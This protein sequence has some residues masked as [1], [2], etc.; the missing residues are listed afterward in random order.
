MLKTI[1]MT[2]LCLAVVFAAGGPAHA[3]NYNLEKMKTIPRYKGLTQEEF[4]K[5]TKVIEETPPGDRHL[6]YSIRFPA[7]WKKADDSS[8]IYESGTKE[9]HALSRRILGKVSKFYGPAQIDATSY[10][11]VRALELD[12]QISARNWF[13][14]FIISNAY[15]LEGMEVISDRRVEALY[16]LNERGTSYVVRAI[17]EINGPRMVLASYY[18]PDA[19]W[20]EEKAM[21]EK[22]VGSFTFLTPEDTKIEA[23]RTYNYL[24]VLHFD[25]PAN[26]RLMAPEAYSLE[27][28]DAKLVNSRDDLTVSGEIE[29]HVVSTEMDTTL[30]Q[31][32]Q[33]L[34]E[35][36]KQTGLEIGDLIEVPDDHEFADHVLFSRVEVYRAKARKPGRRIIDHEFWLGIIVEDRYY[37]IVTMLTP[38]RNAEFYTWARNTEA[39]E[40]VAESMRP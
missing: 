10:F 11:E 33:A 5:Q 4:E 40:I 35:N 38:S 36:L 19:H 31:E 39:F 16:V 1:L 32:V 30:S 12:Y 21:Q 8:S 37:Y 29:I 15:S 22:V 7:G 14:N 23:T 26:W 24:D 6:A 28:M 17:A 13:L 18:L 9:K 34:R 2:A 3:Q 27:G 20:N 25:Y